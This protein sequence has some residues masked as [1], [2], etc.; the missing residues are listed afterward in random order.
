MR[1][2]APL[3]PT[4]WLSSLKTSQLQRIAQATGIRTAGPKPT[5]ITRLQ[6]ELTQYAYPPPPHDHQ[7][8]TNKPPLSILSIDMGIRNLAFAHLLVPNTTALTNPITPTLNAWRRLAVSDLGVLDSPME[9]STERIEDEQKKEIE[10]GKETF[11]PSLYAPQAYTLVSTL[12]AR[13]RPTHVLIERQRFRSGG[14]SA[15]QEWTL[16]VGVFE[17][18]LHA[19]L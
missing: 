13:Y 4:T 17:G 12:L 1:S 9:P 14:G 10:N 19:V 3:N 5:L 11:H 8:P 15:V 7:G 6:T 2:S 18:M 16:R